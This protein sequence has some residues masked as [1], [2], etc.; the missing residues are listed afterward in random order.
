MLIVLENPQH[1]LASLI[2]GQEESE[3]YQQGLQSQALQQY[4]ASAMENHDPHLAQIFL[5]QMQQ[6]LQQQQQ[7][8]T[9]YQNPPNSNLF[10]P[11]H[12]GMLQNYNALLGTPPTQPVV[13]P[14]FSMSSSSSGNDGNQS[15]SLQTSTIDQN[16]RSPYLS[17]SALDFIRR[18]QTLETSPIRREDCGSN[19]FQNFSPFLSGTVPLQQPS[20][21]LQ[22]TASARNSF[23]ESNAPETTPLT[24]IFASN[25]GLKLD[26]HPCMLTSNVTAHLKGT[27]LHEKSQSLNGY[28]APTSRFGAEPNFEVTNALVQQQML[29]TRGSLN[30]NLT[31]EQIAELS[32]CYAQTQ[33]LQTAD[34][35]KS[36]PVAPEFT[37]PPVTF[38]NKPNGDPLQKNSTLI[39][40][41]HGRIEAQQSQQAGGHALSQHSL[42]ESEVGKLLQ[43]A[44]QL[45]R[46][47]ND[48]HP[49]QPQSAGKLGHRLF[50]GFPSA[51]PMLNIQQ[52]LI[53]QQQQQQQDFEQTSAISNK[54]HHHPQTKSQTAKQNTSLPDLRTAKDLTIASFARNEDPVI[55]K[56]KAG[57]R[58]T[59]NVPAKPKPQHSASKPIKLEEN[60]DGTKSKPICAEKSRLADDRTGSVVKHAEAPDPS[61]SSKYRGVYWNKTCKAWRSRIWVNQRSE[62]LGNFDDEVEAARA[63]D[64]RAREL[65]RLTALNF[66]D[67][68]LNV[69]SQPSVK[70]HSDPLQSNLYARNSSVLGNEQRL[71]DILLANKSS[72]N[73]R[74]LS[75]NQ[76]MLPSLKRHQPAN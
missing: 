12:T 24:G 58:P 68:F 21:H 72:T 53:L 22:V 44:P 7:Q 73:K 23:V 43:N 6:Q 18:S 75:S 42:H 55:K 51:Q 32:S 67:T 19:Q 59:A 35:V 45:L 10:L 37:R 57:I 64:R 25:L 39:M 13:S 16:G 60:L 62:H 36:L 69:G 20:L 74:P 14:Q 40:S 41:A 54:A 63:F 71:Q 27:G 52:I 46:Q 11:Q 50:P 56:E 70:T 2:F 47:S 5:L 4:F 3:E 30:V 9:F 34:A 8:Q 61:N 38:G 65:G 28:C 33:R 29:S 1:L 66:P 76:A 17:S 31:P 15:S 49:L 26:Q 48:H